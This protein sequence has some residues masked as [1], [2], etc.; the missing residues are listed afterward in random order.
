MEEGRGGRFD[1][2]IARGPVSGF[3][4][5]RASFLEAVTGHRD[6]RTSAHA[7]ADGHLAADATRAVPMP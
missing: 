4:L 2:A 7:V 5:G 1:L 6:S 3:T